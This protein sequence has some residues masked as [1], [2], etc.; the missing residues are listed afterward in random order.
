MD[1]ELDEP[2]PVAKG[3]ASRNEE[4]RTPALPEPIP[5]PRGPSP[6]RSPAG[7]SLYLSDKEL[8]RTQPATDDGEVDE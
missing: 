8:M 7:G 6:A 5:V 1:P 4:G 2:S 3:E